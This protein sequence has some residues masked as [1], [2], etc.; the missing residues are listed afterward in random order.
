M[1]QIGQMVV[2]PSR[3]EVQSSDVFLGYS[4]QYGITIVTSGTYDRACHHIR[5]W[6]K[7]GECLSW[8]TTYRFINVSKQWISLQDIRDRGWRC[9]NS[10]SS[11]RTCLLHQFH[12]TSSILRSWTL[13]TQCCQFI[14]IRYVVSALLSI[15]QKRKTKFDYCN[16]LMLLHQIKNSTLK[17]Q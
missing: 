17:H 16:I 9:I 11:L 6:Y 8:T 7:F 4:I 14:W 1:P 3:P 12:K 10:C 2:V 5:S 13:R 15:E